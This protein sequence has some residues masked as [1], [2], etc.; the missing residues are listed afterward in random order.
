M[1]HSPLVPQLGAFI[2]LEAMGGGGLPIVFQHTGAWAL[3]AWAAGAPHAR[4]TRVAQDVFDANLIP[5]DSDYRMFS[6]R[7]YGTLPGIDVAFLMDSAAYHSYLDQPERIRHGVLQVRGATRAC[8]G[9]W[10]GNAP[11]PGR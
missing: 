7:H 3:E 2:N 6:A 5:A 8:W 11:G 4:G 1:Q 9:G 10:Q